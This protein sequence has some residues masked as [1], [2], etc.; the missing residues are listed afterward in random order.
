LSGPRHLAT[1]EA[2][3]VAAVERH[4]RHAVAVD[5]HAADAEAGNEIL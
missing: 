1:V 2:A 3:D 4:P 5:A